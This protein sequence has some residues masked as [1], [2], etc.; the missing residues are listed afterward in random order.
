MGGGPGVAQNRLEVRGREPW[1]RV[2]VSLETQ[3]SC[4]Q[5]PSWLLGEAV[6]T[7]CL[8][9]GRMGRV[10]S[11]CPPTDWEFSLNFLLTL[12]K[13][14]N[15][16]RKASRKTGNSGSQGWGDGACVWGKLPRMWASGVSLVLSWCLSSWG[17]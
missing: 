11:P 1:G 14:K 7:P 6:S 2:H 5:C 9:G 3:S 10:P 4:P 13:G 8:P 17:P 16:S 15:I 12:G